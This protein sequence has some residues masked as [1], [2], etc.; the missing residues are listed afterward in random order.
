MKKFLFLAATSMLLGIAAAD[1]QRDAELQLEKEAEAFEKSTVSTDPKAIEALR[2]RREWVKANRYKY[3]QQA[4]KKNGNR[5][6][7]AMN[8]PE[9]KYYSTEGVCSWPNTRI[10]PYPK[11][12]HVNTVL[13]FK[14]PKKLGSSTAQYIS[15]YSPEE[16]GYS[17]RYTDDAA[18]IV[19][20]IYVY[21]MPKSYRSV[22]VFSNDAILVDET[23]RV[24]ADIYQ[25]HSD[26]R[27]DEE[28]TPG[29]FGDSNK[30]A[31][32]CFGSEYGANGFYKQK[33]AT[34][35]YS[36]SLLFAKNHKFIKMRITK[37]GGDPKDFD[38]FL[39]VFFADFERKVIFD[40]QTRKRKFEKAV[41]YPIIF[42]N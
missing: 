27:F 20:D 38:K 4:L 23:K 33:T 21:D 25:I 6:L 31:F 14:F 28:I 12:A 36:F 13:N 26:A 9:C 11:I 30:T 40:S 8:P 7:E 15:T 3:Y 24:V 1:E 32:L 2:Q 35:C 22:S 39:K 42:P 10:S 16:L 19:A 34:R 17:I 5:I 41:T 18:N 37:G 29:R